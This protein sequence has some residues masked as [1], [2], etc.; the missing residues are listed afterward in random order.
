MKLKISYIGF[1][2]LLLEASNYRSNLSNPMARHH[3]W[4]SMATSCHQESVICQ[5]WQG[6]RPIY[7]V[8]CH[9]LCFPYL[10]PCGQYLKIV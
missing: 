4:S 6:G 7:L 10:F 9:L 3:Q 1:N 5:S 8:T 2:K